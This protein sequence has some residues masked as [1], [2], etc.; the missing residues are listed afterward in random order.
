[1]RN[2]PLFVVPVDFSPDME[3]TVSAAFALAE[4]CGADVHL[5]EVVPPRGPSLLDTTTDTRL[6]GRVTSNRDWSR[7]EDSIEA[8]KGGR[9]HV[10]TVAYRGEATRIVTSYVHLV[11]ATLLAIGQHYG[12]PRWRR[13]TRIVSALSRAAPAPVLVLPPRRGSEKNKSLSFDHI[14]SAVDFTVAS[15]V[16]VRTVLDLIRRTGARLTLVHALKNAPHHMVFSGGEAIR[17]ARNLRGQAAQVADHLRRKIPA[18]ASIRVDARVTSGDPH[19]GILDIASEVKADLIVMGVPPR[20]RVDEV[21]FGSTLRS[22]L[23][24]TKIPVLVLPVPAG[25]Y[26][27]LEETDG[28]EVVVRPRTSQPKRRLAR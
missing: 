10:R 24:R 12:T 15:A 19:R 22:V 28:V 20:S 18:N 1:M 3:A 9:I 25:A 17:V 13:N 6:G 7:L 21:L 5:L 2:A 11:K 23:R 16:A 8:A 26:R 4:K 27:W 14:V